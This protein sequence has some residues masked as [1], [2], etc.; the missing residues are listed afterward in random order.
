LIWFR[1]TAEADGETTFGTLGTIFDTRLGIYTGESVAA[2]TLIAAADDLA[3]SRSVYTS[4]ARFAAR[5]GQTGFI[6][7]DGYRDEGAGAEPAEAGGIV[8]NWRQKVAAPLTLVNPGFGPAGCSVTV[9]GTAGESVVLGRGT[10]L[11]AWREIATTTLGPDGAGVLE[12]PA[13]P[14]TG[15]ACYRIVRP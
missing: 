3:S 1:W 6:A 8:L 12:D 14:Q 4:R 15:G 13:A 2:L 9:G 11:A 5:A 10:T 7:V